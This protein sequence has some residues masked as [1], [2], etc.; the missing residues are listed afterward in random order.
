MNS[1]EKL[2]LIL[3]KITELNDSHI[4]LIYDLSEIHREQ[5]TPISKKIYE[6]LSKALNNFDKNNVD[7]IN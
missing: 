7:E 5:T 2:D 1:K 6:Q 3:S 4:N